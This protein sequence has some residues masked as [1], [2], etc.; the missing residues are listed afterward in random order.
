M[1]NRRYHCRLWVCA[2][3]PYVQFIHMY[4]YFERIDEPTRLCLLMDLQHIPPDVCIL[5][6]DWNRQSLCGE[7]LSVTYSI[8]QCSAWNRIYI[9]A[10]LDLDI[11]TF[12]QKY[13]D[14]VQKTLDKV[15]KHHTSLLRQLFPT[16]LSRGSGWDFHPDLK[17]TPSF[18]FYIASLLSFSGD[19]IFRHVRSVRLNR[20]GQL[21]R[22]LPGKWPYLLWHFAH[23]LLAVQTCVPLVSQQEGK[24]KLIYSFIFQCW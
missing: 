10:V 11:K 3:P 13:L 23:S 5:L 16:M 18:D 22:W 20:T 2:L 19:H 1:L 8:H 15:S 17:Y 9:I 21:Q 24:I 6:N 7:F 12:G 4:L 14:V